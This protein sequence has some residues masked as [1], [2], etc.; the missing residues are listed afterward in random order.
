M[1]C[2]YKAMETSKSTVLSSAPQSL[3]SRLP[4]PTPQSPPSSYSLWEHQQWG[5]LPVP[6]WAV[7]QHVVLEQPC[8]SFQPL[9]V[10]SDLYVDIRPV[11]DP[12]DLFPLKK[13][14]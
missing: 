6:S 7:D 10:L 3:A 11:F 5:I 12:R 1:V 8:L 9:P 4:V 14:T 2:Y 13:D